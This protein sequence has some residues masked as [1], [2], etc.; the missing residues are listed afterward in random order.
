VADRFII[1]DRGRA[2]AL[3]TMDVLDD[4]VVAK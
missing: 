4:S 2:V 1:M 3:G